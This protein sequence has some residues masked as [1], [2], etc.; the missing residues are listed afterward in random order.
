VVHIGIFWQQG[1][2]FKN[3]S[4]R[5]VFEETSASEVTLS[6]KIS[7]D[8]ITKF[9]L[10][11]REAGCKKGRLQR[12]DRFRRQPRRPDTQYRPPESSASASYCELTIH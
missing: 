8:H 3:H 12:F 10:G 2:T 9:H 11:V 1:T 6:V 5:I 7:A 4:K